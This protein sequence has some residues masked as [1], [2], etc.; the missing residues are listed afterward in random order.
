MPESSLS[1]EVPSED[2]QS[3]LIGGALSLEFSECSIAAAD[4]CRKVTDQLHVTL[5]YIDYLKP[6]V[7]HNF[8]VVGEG[9]KKK[10]LKISKLKSQGLTLFGQQAKLVLAQQLDTYV[11]ATPNKYDWIRMLCGLETSE[12][13]SGRSILGDP[14]L[15]VM[16]GAES[17]YPLATFAK[18][19]SGQCSYVQLGPEIEDDNLF[20]TT[21]DENTSRFGIIEDI[22]K[23]IAGD[24]NN[25]NSETGTVSELQRFIDSQVAINRVEIAAQT[26]K[27]L[28]GHIFQL[29]RKSKIRTNLTD[30]AA[31]GSVSHGQYRTTEII[32]ETVLDDSRSVSVV[33]AQDIQDAHRLYLFA[34]TRGNIVT[35]I[36]TARSA[37]GL[38]EF[39]N[40]TDPSNER[41][42]EIVRS[43][44]FSL[45]ASYAEKYPAFINRRQDRKVP[46][47]SLDILV[48]QY[49]KSR[50]VLPFEFE[51]PTE[52]GHLANKDRKIFDIFEKYFAYPDVSPPEFNSE[53]IEH[54]LVHYQYDRT[55]QLKILEVMGVAETFRDILGE[56]RDCDER[57]I[58]YVAKLAL[59]G[60]ELVSTFENFRIGKTVAAAELAAKATK[61]QDG[62]DLMI[63][64][65]PVALDATPM[66]PLLQYKL[67]T[68]QP[69]LGLEDKI[70]GIHSEKN[71]AEIVSMLAKIL[72]ENYTP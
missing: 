52:E 55:R 33:A 14:M 5:E 57:L 6:G 51:A 60:K 11:A 20:V 69:Y 9:D 32:P 30:L 19:S 2:D 10:D 39:S 65:K 64:G 47:S 15:A 70:H 25:R 31:D 36:A 29:L 71:I 63:S 68:Q 35:L 50:E 48:N 27:E 53:F 21:G 61:V 26:E 13:N 56:P 22:R 28:I 1:P 59:E 24:Y 46:K 45:T 43:L 17:L 18:R 67:A 38:L 8:F 49:L 34:K 12:I 37:D 4:L 58:Y 23:I 54:L 40:K 3:S 42:D 44:I 7:T 62:Y 41:R 66:T 16:I 72:S